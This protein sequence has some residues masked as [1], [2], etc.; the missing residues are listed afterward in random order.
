MNE[1]SQQ[2]YPQETLRAPYWIRTVSA[3]EE[4]VMKSAIISK[5]VEFA[6]EG[7]EKK[8]LSVCVE[9]MAG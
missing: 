1:W 9:D 6:G 8:D 2:L 5:S 4:R 7:F 3:T